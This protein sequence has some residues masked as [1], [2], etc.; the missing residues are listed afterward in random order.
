MI[1]GDVPCHEKFAFDTLEQQMPRPA[2]APPVLSAPLFLE[3]VYEKN[4]RNTVRVSNSLDLSGQTWAS[5]VCKQ[6]MTETMPPTHPLTEMPGVAHK[7]HMWIKLGGPGPLS[8]AVF[9]L[10]THRLLRSYED[11]TTA[12]SLI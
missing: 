9:C 5:T 4:I 1:D 12:L 2:C 6:K 10:T 3:S 11:G 7:R 8:I